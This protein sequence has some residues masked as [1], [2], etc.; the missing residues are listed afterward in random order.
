MI[1]ELFVKSEN[2]YEK[3]IIRNYDYSAALQS[4]Q[5]TCFPPPFPE[6]L[7]WSKE[8]LDSHVRHFNEGAMCAEINGRLVGSMT[9][10][11]VA[12]DP[13]KPGHTWEEV[14]DNGFIRT[15]NE[16]GNTLYIADISVDPEYRKLGIGKWLMQTMY[17][18]VVHRR[19]ERLLGGG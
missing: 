17:E 5:Q 19:L 2:G 4:L 15:H 11:I 7:L 16:N 12:F 13:S 18:L 14:T 1:K 6:E 10:L 3:M 9:S 8:Q